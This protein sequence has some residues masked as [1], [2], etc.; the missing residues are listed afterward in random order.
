METIVLSRE[1]VNGILH[2]LGGRPYAEV[3]ALV[4][5][6]RKDLSGMNGKE[7]REDGTEGTDSGE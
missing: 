5:C 2:Y 1:T 6:I 3:V 7:E 4:D